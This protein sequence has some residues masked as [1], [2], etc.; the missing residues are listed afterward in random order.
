[1]LSSPQEILPVGCTEKKNQL[2]NWSSVWIDCCVNDI[3]V[4]TVKRQGIVSKLHTR[5]KHLFTNSKCQNKKSADRMTN[6]V[7]RNRKPCHAERHPRVVEV[8]DSAR[9]SSLNRCVFVCGLCADARL[10]GQKDCPLSP[11]EI[12]LSSTISWKETSVW[13]NTHLSFC[14]VRRILTNIRQLSGVIS[15]FRHPIEAVVRLRLQERG[16]VFEVGL[17]AFSL[18]SCFTHWRRATLIWTESVFERRRKDVFQSSPSRWYE[19]RDISKST[20]FSCCI[21]QLLS[22]ESLSCFFFVPVWSCKFHDVS[23]IVNKLSSPSPCSVAHFSFLFPHSELK[24]KPFL[25]AMHSNQDADTPIQPE[26]WQTIGTG[27]S[28]SDL[29]F[30]VFELWEQGNIGCFLTLFLINLLMPLF[31]VI[32]S[33]SSTKNLKF[34]PVVEALLNRL[35]LS[36]II[37]ALCRHSQHTASEIPVVFVSEPGATIYISCFNTVG[38]R[39][40]LKKKKKNGSPPF[41]SKME[42]YFGTSPGAFL[43]VIWNCVPWNEAK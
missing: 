39:G 11:V 40:W 30:A 16:S 21:S 35:L 14:F 19:S 12:P 36:E 32:F 8:Y 22:V 2:K 34:P 9:F 42:T 31:P 7:L 43:C 13:I 41:K 33:L 29:C 24:S 37:S 10:K 25:H 15:C 4:M 20:S 6:D 23:N 5:E 1:M 27:A 26:R 18:G 28:I 3:N 38:E 17:Y